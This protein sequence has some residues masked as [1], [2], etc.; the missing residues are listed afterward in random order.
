MAQQKRRTTRATKEHEA[1]ARALFSAGAL[2][3]GDTL[4]TAAEWRLRT[5]LDAVNDDTIELGKRLQISTR[6]AQRLRAMFDFARP[7]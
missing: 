1:L 4:R 2:P 5:L 6:H 7:R 3:D